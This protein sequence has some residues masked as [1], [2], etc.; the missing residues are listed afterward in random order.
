[1]ILRRISKHVKDQNWFAVGLDFCIVVVGILL[2]FQITNWSE[3][4]SDRTQERQ[5]IERLYADFEKLGRDVDASIEMMG[6]IVDEI[7]TIKELIIKGSNETDLQRLEEFYES[8]FGLQ[9]IAGLSDTYEQLISS[10][11]MNLISNDELRSALVIHASSTRD[12][13]RQDQA[14]REWSRP[15]MVPFIRLRSLIKTMPLDEAL[16]QAGSKADLIVAMDM[17]E[18]VFI[19]QL[20]QHKA[21]KES[22]ANVTEMLASEKDK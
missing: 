8:E 21:H 19:G 15:Y 3:A 10:G 16:T 4:R 14:M 1:M 18:G 12:F 22:F 7:E 9:S 6:P 5:I 11:D 20:G 17:Y 13:M 2:A